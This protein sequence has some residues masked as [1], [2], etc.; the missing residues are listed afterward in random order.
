MMR[1]ASLI[2]LPIAAYIDSVISEN[3]ALLDEEIFISNDNMVG[4]AG[5][6]RFLSPKCW[7]ISDLLF[8]DD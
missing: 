3:S 8:F 5:V 1:S 4:G 7:K 6:I 2:K